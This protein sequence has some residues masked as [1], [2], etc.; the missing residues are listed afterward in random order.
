MNLLNK[1]VQESL[2]NQ[3]GRQIS[4]FSSITEPLKYKIVTTVPI[5]H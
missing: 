2:H 4:V 5:F 1:L 3:A